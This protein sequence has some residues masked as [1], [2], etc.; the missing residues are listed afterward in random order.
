M[1]KY[2]VYELI[3]LMGSVEDVGESYRPNYRLYQHTK[4]M[5]RNGI[6]GYGKY[7]GRQDLVMNIVAEFDNK[8]D[9]RKLEGELKLSYGMNWS[10]KDRDIKNG[11]KR[12]KP[13]LV[14]KKDGTYVGEFYSLHECARVLKLN[15]SNA[16]KVCNG[17]LN[18]TGGYIIKYKM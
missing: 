18:H 3:N 2:Y 16:G 17:K 15:C 9:A 6:S 11:L 14:Y 13:V 8:S 1:K 5:P 7:Y 4:V 10:E 12:S